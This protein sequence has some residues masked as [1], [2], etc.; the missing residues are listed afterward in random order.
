MSVRSISAPWTCESCSGTSVSRSWSATADC[1]VSMPRP[2]STMRPDGWSGASGPSSRARE[3]RPMEFEQVVKKRFMCRSYEDRDVP[4]EVLERILDLARRYPSAGHTQPQEFI[5]IRNQ[6]TKLQIAAA[7]L[8]QMYV[9]EAPVVVAVISDTRRSYA[10]YRER[11]A[12]F[13]SIID[14][15]FAA[16]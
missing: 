5:V 13:Y 10:R 8:G 3:R 6:A 14:G 9:A 11:G 16:M 2:A 7:A 1:C 4:D 15:A 12:N